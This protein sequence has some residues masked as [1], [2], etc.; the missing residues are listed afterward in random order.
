MSLI[1][2][3]PERLPARTNADHVSLSSSQIVKEHDKDK[4]PVVRP[5][6]SVENQTFIRPGS[7]Q[8][9]ANLRN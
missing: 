2:R 3:S 1:R 6:T 7:R 4:N 8:E 5:A 9:V